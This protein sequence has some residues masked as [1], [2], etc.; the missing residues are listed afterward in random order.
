MAYLQAYE[1]GRLSI[2][3]RFYHFT[4]WCVTWIVQELPK[5]VVLE[6]LHKILRTHEEV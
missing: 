4:L 3:A 5:L 6:E 2:I 1:L